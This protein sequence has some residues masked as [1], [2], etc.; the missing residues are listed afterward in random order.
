MKICFKIICLQLH[1]GPTPPSASSVN[2]NVG[3]GAVANLSI[4]SSGTASMTSGND[5]GEERAARSMSPN[6][7]RQKLDFFANE[8]VVE[9]TETCSTIENPNQIQTLKNEDS[10]NEFNATDAEGLFC[11]GQESPSKYQTIIIQ[12]L[13]NNCNNSLINTRHKRN[14]VPTAAED[15]NNFTIL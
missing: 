14:I 4:N 5:Q 6:A 13:G 10:D 8:N 1:G 7:K 12:L 11:S 9:G 3:S 15:K 2:G